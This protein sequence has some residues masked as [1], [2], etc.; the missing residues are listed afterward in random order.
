MNTNFKQTLLTYLKCNFPLI[1]I[2]TIEIDRVIK[3]ILDVVNEFNLWLPSC[4]TAPKSLKLKGL[5]VLKWDI[6]SG[7]VNLK[8][9]EELKNTAY[10]VNMF[11][12]IL[13]D[14]SP[15]GVYIIEHFHLNMDEPRMALHVA[16]LRKM[17]NKCKTKNKHLLFISP[18]PKI[19]IEIRDLFAV[20][21]FKLPNYKERFDFIQQEVLARNCKISKHEIEQASEISAGMTLNEIENALS[22]ALVLSKGKHINPQII[23][24]EK[25]KSVKRSG[26]LEI[27]EVDYGLEAVGG[28]SR[29]KEW[30]MKV[31]KV[32][33]N[34]RQAIK[35]KLPIP[36]G[37]LI[38]GVSGT[39]KS[40]LAKAIA[41]EFGVPLY[42]ADVGRLYSSLVGETE[43]NTRELFKL[44]E[45]LAP[46]VVLFDE[47]EKLFSGLESSS[48]SD[49]GTTARLIGN[50]LYFM[51]EKT[52]PAYFVATANNVENIAPELLRAGRWD[53]IWFVDL[54]SFEERI[55]IFKIHI[56][57]TG[58]DLKKFPNI[59]IL[60]LETDKYTGAEI[61]N[62]VKSAMFNAFYEN[63]D[64]TQEDLLKAIKEVKPIS[65]F[66]EEQVE[67]L[68]NWALYR[69]KRAN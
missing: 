58:R 5:S 67:Y 57:K 6:H 55:E 7:L 44:I 59:E 66:K 4:E 25:T 46:C 23:A 49:S 62:I 60:A 31:A 36:K 34:L 32:F 3:E 21:E 13:K 9:N 69:A 11:E 30:A 42:R 48:A 43:S 17:F 14:D 18:I 63:R 28:L 40:L 29:F 1:Y 12:Y 45:A 64:F 16:L 54:P 47:I 52:V 2:E 38:F 24:N 27:M 56:Q 10:P 41:K 65:K 15:S 51:Q 61:E 33:K 22:V 26:L 50:F 39:G 37:C 20:V 35:Y 8:T 53:E 68:R 19:P